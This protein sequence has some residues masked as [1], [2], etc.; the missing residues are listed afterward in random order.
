VQAV[1]QQASWCVRVEREAAAAAHGLCRP[2][3]QLALAR[4]DV[5]LLSRSESPAANEVA[6]LLRDPAFQRRSA[7][8]LRVLL[9]LPE[10]CAPALAPFT[11]LE[12]VGLVEDYAS[13]GDK[14]HAAAMQLGALAA[15]PCLRSLQLEGGVAELAALPLRVAELALLDVDRV[16][17]PPAPGAS[18]ADRLLAAA[19]AHGEAGLDGLSG[20]VAAAGLAG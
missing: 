4:L 11:C 13:T 6:E 20:P 16:A 2:L 9:G 12:A 15:L 8:T 7:A 1:L 19:E 5:R 10:R 3:R 18:V 14:S 17:L